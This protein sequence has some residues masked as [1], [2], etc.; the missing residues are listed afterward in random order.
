EGEQNEKGDYGSRD[1]PS[2][3]ERCGKGIRFIGLPLL[4]HGISD[5]SIVHRGLFSMTGSKVRFAESIPMPFL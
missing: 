5:L 4:A 3:R 2:F 1:A